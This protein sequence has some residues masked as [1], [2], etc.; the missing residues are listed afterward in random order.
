MGVWKRF[1]ENFR[2]CIGCNFGAKCPFLTVLGL[3]ESLDI[4]LYNGTGPIT[5]YSLSSEIQLIKVGHISKIFGKS[6]ILRQPYVEILCGHWP[7]VFKRVFEAKKKC[8]HIFPS[9][10]RPS[11]VVGTSY[12]VGLVLYTC[13]SKKKNG[14][15]KFSVFI[16]LFDGFLPLAPVPKLQRR[17]YTLKYQLFLYHHT[18]TKKTNNHQ[19]KYKNWKFW[20]PKFFL[21]KQVYKINP[22]KYEVP[23]TS[24]GGE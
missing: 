17:C 23:T 13:L 6:Q 5:K 4:D 9:Y 21:L 2:F 15:S 22:T 16:R 18:H 19:K 14:S 3:F 12:L 8:N 1:F 10:S 7:K 11:E 20:T 24:D